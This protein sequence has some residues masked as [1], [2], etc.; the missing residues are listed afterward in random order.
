[1][2]REN[3]KPRPGK[4]ESIDAWHGGGTPHSIAEVP[5]MGMERRGCIIWPSRSGGKL[6]VIPGG[7][8]GQK[9]KHEG[10]KTISCVLDNKSRMM[11]EYHV[12]IYKRLG[13]KFPGST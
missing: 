13:V 7:T 6:G 4:V 2:L 9:A 8:K 5:V 12:R 11:R 10:I 1:M 3:T